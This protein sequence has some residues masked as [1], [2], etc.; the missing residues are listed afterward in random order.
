M[1]QAGGVCVRETFGILAFGDHLDKNN[2]H[3]EGSVSVPNVLEQR[4]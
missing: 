4:L 1:F 2:N 3:N